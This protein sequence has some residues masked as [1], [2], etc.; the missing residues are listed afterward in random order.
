MTVMTTAAAALLS[1]GLMLSGSQVR[2]LPAPAAAVAGAPDM[3][4]QVKAR[5]QL[6]VTS[7]HTEQQVDAYLAA[8][9]GRARH[10][11]RVTPLEVAPG[12]R[13]IRQ[14][15]GKIPLARLTEK[16]LAFADEMREL[17][18]ELR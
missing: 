12:L 4:D 16:E 2:A 17:A 9:R 3:R 18:E 13:A 1:G 5:I 11:R 14:L 15:A 6:E 8:L 7:L 10:N